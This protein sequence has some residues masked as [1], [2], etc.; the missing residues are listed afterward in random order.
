MI[1]WLAVLLAFGVVVAYPHIPGSSS[2]AFAGVSLFFGIIFSLG[3]TSLI[4]N[5]IAGYMM[6]YRRAFRVGDRVKIGDAMGDVIKMRLQ[7][8]HLRSFKNEEIVIPNSQILSGE[9]LNYSSL[10]K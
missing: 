7:V 6:T 1:A 5:I 3:S 9:V 8:T 4:A 10:A 2:T